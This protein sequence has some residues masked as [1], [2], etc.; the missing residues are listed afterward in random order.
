MNVKLGVALL[1]FNALGLSARAE[2]TSTSAY[3]IFGKAT[4]MLDVAKANKGEFF[5]LEQ[6]KYSVIEKAAQD[7][8]FKAYWEKMAKEQKMSPEA[9]EKSAADKASKKVSDKEIKEAL[10]K[11][12][13]LPELQKFS[14]EEREKQV[15]SY[16]RRNAVQDAM[17]QILENARKNQELVVVYP[18]P[19]EPVYDVPVLATDVVKFGPN[20]SDIKPSG[21]KGDD[22]PITVVEYS[23]FECPYCSRVIPDVKKV[24]A[25]YKGKIRW[26]VRDYPLPFHE[27]AKPAAIA[28]KCAA[29]QGK[30]WDMYALLFENQQNLKDEDFLSHAKTMSL[31]LDKFKKCV[32]NPEPLLAKIEANTESGSKLGVNGTPAF[33]INGVRLSGALPYNEFKRIIDGQL[34]KKR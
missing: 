2:N 31:N 13:D 9:A 5:E 32:N 22:C 18:R 33:F 24:L 17:G 6:K 28:A 7:A 26:I 15:S 29:E 19:S 21:C 25:E 4:S 11:F 8:F 10:L 34:T 3:Q 16:L 30:Y 14:P 23:E 1:I 12:K 20:P 27:R